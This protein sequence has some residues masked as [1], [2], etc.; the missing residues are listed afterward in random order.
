MG[1]ENVIVGYEIRDFQKGDIIPADAVFIKTRD[2]YAGHVGWISNLR[3][4]YRTV[5][6]YQVPIYKKRNIKTTIK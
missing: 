5:Y 1:W 6:E 3:A 2:V 4:S